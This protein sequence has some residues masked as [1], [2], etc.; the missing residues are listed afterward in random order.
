M[1]NLEKIRKMSPAQLAAMLHLL[2]NC[3]EISCTNCPLGAEHCGNIPN[4]VEW[5]EK[6]VHDA[7]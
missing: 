4:I 3:Q 2:T 5:L 7:P 6:E 1:T